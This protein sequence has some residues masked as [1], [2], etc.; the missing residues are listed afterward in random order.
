MAQL[1]MRRFYATILRDKSNA[2]AAQIPLSSATISIYKQGATVSSATTVTASD[3]AV[4]VY[5]YGRLASGDVVQLNADDTKLMT[6]QSVD[7]DTQVTLVKLTTANIVL[8]VGDRLVPRTNRPT[9]YAD[10]TGTLEKTDTPDM[11]TDTQGQISFYIPEMRFDYIASGGGITTT[12][13]IDAEGGWMRDGMAVVNVR[14][15]PTFQAAIDATS[16]SIGGTLYIPTGTYSAATIPAVGSLTVTGGLPFK[17]VGD[18]INK[19]TINFND[20]ANADFLTITG[21]GEDFITIS[22]MTINGAGSAGSGRCIV[23][24]SCSAL[25]IK[26]MWIT[27]FPS[28]GIDNADSTGDS[29]D[30]TIQN[31]RIENNVTNGAIRLS[32]YS[33]FWKILN[34][35]I[36]P[37]AGIGI[38]I[39][40]STMPIIRDCDF[41]FT[42]DT[43]STDGDTACMIYMDSSPDYCNVARIDS[44]WFECTATNATPNNWMIFINGFNNGSSIRDCYFVRTAGAVTSCRAIKTMDTTGGCLGLVIDNPTMIIGGTPAGTDDIVLSANSS[45]CQVLGGMRSKTDWSTTT[46]LR[47]I[48]VS[49]ANPNGVARFNQNLRFKLMGLSTAGRDALTDPKAGDLIFNTDTGVVNFYNGAVWGAI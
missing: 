11:E 47:G 1:E 34:C 37:A 42:H 3:T 46:S 49:M 13:Y 48:R 43:A 27:G 10:S 2:D 41:N 19:T 26:D 45:L 29:V 38:Y 23:V 30:V 20:D 39:D 14:S 25:I 6:V 7:N 33:F 5:N 36:N 31:C 40:G 12:L 22:D 44:C 35:G 32:K 8:S 17:M 21:P 4:A 9:A 15:F 18:G 24:K 16:R 28:W